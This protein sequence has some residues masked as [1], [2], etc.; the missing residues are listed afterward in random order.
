VYTL[1]RLF[2]LPWYGEISVSESRGNG[3]GRFG[4]CHAKALNLLHERL[5]MRIRSTLA[6]IALGFGV[7]LVSA[8]VAL[9]DTAQ[10]PTSSPATPTSSRPAAQAPPAPTSRPA[11]SQTEASKRPEPQVVKPRGAAE[12]GSGMD[13]ESTPTGGLVLGGAALLAMAGVGTVGVR[14]LRRQG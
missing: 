11:T 5:F 9:A 6:G 2:R 3:F 4:V 14:R 12:T 8:P 13:N 1:E 10:T 7:L